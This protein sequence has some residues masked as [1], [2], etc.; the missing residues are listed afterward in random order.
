MRNSILLMAIQLCV[1]AVS[2]SAFSQDFN[3]EADRYGKLADS[4]GEAKQYKAAARYYNAEGAARKMLAYKRQPAVNAAYFYAM[5]QMPDSALASLRKAVKQYGFTNRNWMDSEAALAAVRKYKAYSDLLRFMSDKQ[6]AQ[7][8]PDRAAVITSD[9]GLFWKVYDQYKKR[10]F[11]CPEVI[12]H[13][14]F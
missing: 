5:A 2:T 1:L 11:Q 12:S 8:D 6:D 13:R 14:I 10:L 4:L 3:P 7:L 9:I